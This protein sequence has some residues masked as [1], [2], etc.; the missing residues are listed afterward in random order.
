MRFRNVCRIFTSSTNNK[1]YNNFKKHNIMTTLKFKNLG[2]FLEESSNRYQSN[3][4]E[5][6]NVNV[7]KCEYRNEWLYR[8]IDIKFGYEL[9]LNGH[10][11]SSFETKKECLKELNLILNNDKDYILEIESDSLKQIKLYTEHFKT[12]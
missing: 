8:F 7:F 9:D 12:Y 11:C 5:N 3:F 10:I 6:S 1:Y 4:T 2:K